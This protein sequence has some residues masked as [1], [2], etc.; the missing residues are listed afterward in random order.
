MKKRVVHYE[1][2]DTFALCGYCPIYEWQAIRNWRKVTCKRCLKNRRPAVSG[3][4]K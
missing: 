3:E 1:L 2:P 4:G